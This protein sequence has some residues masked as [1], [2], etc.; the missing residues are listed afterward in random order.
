VR[1]TIASLAGVRSRGSAMS[2]SWREVTQPEVAAIATREKA[3]MTMRGAL[4]R[5]MPRA[6]VDLRRAVLDER[7]AMLAKL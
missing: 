7:A 6:M 4:S 3:R 2:L 1:A 5:R